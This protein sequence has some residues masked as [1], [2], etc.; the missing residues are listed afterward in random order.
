MQMEAN[1]RP[2][3]AMTCTLAFLAR[4]LEAVQKLPWLNS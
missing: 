4:V 1:S 2:V 3:V